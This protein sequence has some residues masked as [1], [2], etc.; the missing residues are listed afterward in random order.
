MPLYAYD[1]FERAAGTDLLDRSGELGA[2]TLR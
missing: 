1:T 2:S